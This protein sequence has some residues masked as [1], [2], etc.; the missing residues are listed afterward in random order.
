MVSC[1]ES[2]EERIIRKLSS[3][4]ESRGLEIDTITAE[5]TTEIVISPKDNKEM[6]TIIPLY[7]FSSVE[8]RDSLD[9]LLSKKANE[10]QAWYA[11][12]EWDDKRD[13][14]SPW[15]RANFDDPKSE[16]YQQRLTPNYILTFNHT[17]TKTHRSTTIGKRLLDHWKMTEKEFKEWSWNHLNLLYEKQSELVKINFK[18]RELLHLKCHNIH[19]QHTLIFSENFKKEVSEKVGY[20]FYVILNKNFPVYISKKN[21]LAYLNQSLA[22][23]ESGIKQKDIF[24][25]ELITYTEDGIEVSEIK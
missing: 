19:H 22:E 12:P 16:V 13:I 23:M 15:L 4:L 7:E 2:K 14:F 8:N 11:L 6:R 9:F 25:T 3:E 18:G 17:N 10:I 24:P 20:P 5:N 1:L 21:D